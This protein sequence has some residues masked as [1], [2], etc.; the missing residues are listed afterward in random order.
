MVSKK[1]ASIYGDRE[2]LAR[3]GGRVRALRL[4]KNQTQASV[5]RLAGTSIPTYQKLEAGDGTIALGVF[6]RVIAMM[7]FADRLGD[8]VPEAEPP[9][10]FKALMKPERQRARRAREGKS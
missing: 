7:G 1:T 4:Q 2:A 5:A 3:A 8:V 10:D 9:V 6:A